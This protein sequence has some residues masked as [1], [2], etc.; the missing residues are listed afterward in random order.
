M[1]ETLENPNEGIKKDA[2]YVEMRVD[3]RLAGHDYEK[4]KR[5]SFYIV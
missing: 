3:R 5:A 2:G 4:S 1:G